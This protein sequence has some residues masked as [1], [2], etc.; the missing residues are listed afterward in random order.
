MPK[1]TRDPG[2]RIGPESFYELFQ[3][4]ARGAYRAGRYR[5]E[6]KPGDLNR[7]ERETVDGLLEQWWLQELGEVPDNE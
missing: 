4:V 3:E 5:G 7:I 6:F 2:P 1:A